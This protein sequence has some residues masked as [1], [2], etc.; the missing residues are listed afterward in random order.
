MQS[1]TTNPSMQAPGMKR[2]SMVRF[3]AQR[4]G[5]SDSEFDAVGER[6]RQATAANLAGGGRGIVGN[7]KKCQL[8]SLVIEKRVG[9]RGIAIAR[10]A[11]GTDDRDP[12]AMPGNGNRRARNRPEFAHAS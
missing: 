10:L 7:A 3:D 9:R 5:N 2:S 4:A 12:A 6:R 8:R 1:P 11:H